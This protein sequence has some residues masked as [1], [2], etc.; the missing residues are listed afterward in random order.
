[1]R[2]ETN[3]AAHLRE[4]VF[5]AVDAREGDRFE[6]LAASS[7]LGTTLWIARNRDMG[8]AVGLRICD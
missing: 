2:I 4:G 5:Y 1:M 3:D 7:S 8:I 6:V